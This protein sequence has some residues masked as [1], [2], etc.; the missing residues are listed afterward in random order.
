MPVIRIIILFLLLFYGAYATHVAKQNVEQH[1]LT[2]KRLKQVKMELTEKDHAFIHMV[3]NEAKF[4]SKHDNLNTPVSVIVKDG[5]VIGKGLDRSTSLTDPTA[6]AELEAVKEA[7]GYLNSS[8]LKGSVVYSS[9]QPCPMCLSLLHLTKVDKLIYFMA[10]DS[11]GL[12]DT[13]LLNQEI[14]KSLMKA[15]SERSIQ[16]VMLLPGDLKRSFLAD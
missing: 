5:K 4:V 6:H 13:Q 15:P 14:Y 3:L 16:E 10:P 12:S 8:S 7:S 11:M 9:A 1:K 2:A